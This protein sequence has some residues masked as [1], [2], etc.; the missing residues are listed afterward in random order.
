MGCRSGFP[1]NNPKTPGRSILSRNARNVARERTKR[2]FQV[3][4][5]CAGDGGQVRCPGCRAS[6]PPWPAGSPLGDRP[7]SPTA[8]IMWLVHVGV[9]EPSPGGSTRTRTSPMVEASRPASPASGHRPALRE[10]G[11]RLM[12]KVTTAEVPHAFD[13]AA[14]PVVSKTEETAAR[15][16][17]GRRDWKPVRSTRRFNPAC[18]VALPGQGRCRSAPCRCKTVHCSGGSALALHEPLRVD[19]SAEGTSLDRAL[20][21]GQA[22]KLPV[23][24]RYAISGTENTAEMAGVHETPASGDGRHPES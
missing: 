15:N 8:W 10:G 5:R 7:P 13:A 23:A 20:F 16:M 9:R 17:S 1:S 4:K 3:L 22:V 19:R 6:P 12:K 11:L 24:R 21:T 2:R 14:G 18:Q